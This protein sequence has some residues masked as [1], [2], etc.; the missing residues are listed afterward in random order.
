MALLDGTVVHWTTFLTAAVRLNPSPG[1]DIAFIPG[2]AMRGGRKSGFAAMG[3]IWTGAVFHA[4]CAAVG[5]PGL[6]GD[7]FRSRKMGRGGV[8][9]LSRRKGA[10]LGRWFLCFQ[11]TA[12]PGPDADHLAAWGAG[13]AFESDNRGLFPGVPAAI[14]RCRCGAGLGATVPA[15]GSDHRRGGDNRPPLVL[16]G[17]ELMQG[18]RDRPSLGMWMDRNNRDT[19]H[20]AQAVDFKTY[21]GQTDG[22]CPKTEYQFWV[23]ET[24]PLATY[25][26]RFE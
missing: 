16:L 7:R 22:C 23:E 12:G 8:F 25:P 18:I 15:Q 24:V 3:G 20:R 19:G 2:Q 17:E 10:P 11:G 5:N 1:P 21:F 9:D 6:L 26:D 4:V 14:R 13:V